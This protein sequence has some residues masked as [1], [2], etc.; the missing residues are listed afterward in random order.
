MPVRRLT[1][2]SDEL[3]VLVF[4]RG[5]FM[6]ERQLIIMYRRRSDLFTKVDYPLWSLESQPCAYP[7]LFV[8]QSPSRL[9]FCQ[10]HLPRI[11]SKE[12]LEAI[13]F[14]QE[15]KPFK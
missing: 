13:L 10:R 6:G 12:L 14:R 7:L 4:C 3:V 5:R 2:F 1:D 15:M 9:S 8:P 11:S